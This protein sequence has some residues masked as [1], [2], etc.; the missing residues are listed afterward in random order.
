M[1]TVLGYPLS[2][3]IAVLEAEKL[4]VQLRELTC[5]KGAA[6]SDARI[7][8]QQLLDDQYVLLTYA[9]FETKGTETD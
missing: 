6:G 8:R 2:R 5:R 3:A 4:T 7:V 9:L 1:T